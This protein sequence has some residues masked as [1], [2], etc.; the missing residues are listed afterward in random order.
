MIVRKYRLE[1]GWSQYQL[2]EFSGLNVRTIQRI[3]RGQKASLESLKSLAAVFEVDI[4]DLTEDKPMNSDNRLS[5]EELEAI[6]HVRDIKAFY[7]HLATYIM[8]NLG[9]LIFNLFITPQYLWVFWSAMGWGIG[10]VAHAISVFEVFNLF[11]ANWEQRQ[12]EKRLKKHSKHSLR[13][14]K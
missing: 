9:L 6:E 14:K 7:S 3:E 5:R 12:I 2:A 8:V 13:E 11:D 10:V 4:T 1:R